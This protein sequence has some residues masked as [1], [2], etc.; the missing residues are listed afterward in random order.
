MDSLSSIVLPAAAN[1][2]AIIGNLVN[3]PVVVEQP[4]DPLRAGSI[5]WPRSSSPVPV[6]EHQPALSCPV[7][8]QGPFPDTTVSGKASPNL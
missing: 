4:A 6:F 7:N 8:K 2:L 1:S 5:T 3:L